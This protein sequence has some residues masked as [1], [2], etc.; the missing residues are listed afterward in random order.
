MRTLVLFTIGLFVVIPAFAGGLNPVARGPHIAFDD[1]ADI[2]GNNP[3]VLITYKSYIGLGS[4]L[5]KPEFTYKSGGITKHSDP[6]KLYIMPLISFT[7]KIND[8]MVIGIGVHSPYGLGSKFNNNPQ[9]LGYDTETELSLTNLTIGAGIKLTEKLSAGLY[10]NGGYA[11]FKYIAPFD[12]NSVP[13]PISTKSNGDGFGASVSLGTLYKLTDKLSWGVLYTTKCDAPLHGHTVISIG[14]LQI[15]DAFSSEFKFPDRLGTG[16]SWQIN[17]KWRLGLDVN[18]FW[19]SVDKKMSLKFRKI[20]MTKT[21]ILAWDD[22]Y[23]IHTELWHRL[24]KTTSI[25]FGV[26]YMTAAITK[27]VSTLMPDGTGWDV[28]AKI[29]KDLGKVVIDGQLIYAW[30]NQES[31]RLCQTEK[32]RADVYVA[33]LGISW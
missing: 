1:D 23:S 3:A 25:T 33:K 30:G 16:I 28:T 4:K 24:N 32:Y 5:V 17:D 29:R 18:Y 7:K 12:I 26:D 10:V 8:D 14:P 20:P 21:N 27:T 11:R 6:N 31:N 9:Q 13:L 19:Y 15:R 2:I 22:V